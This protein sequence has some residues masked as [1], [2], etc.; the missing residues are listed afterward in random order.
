MYNVISGI[1]NV[2]CTYHKG[3]FLLVLRLPP[4]DDD[5]GH[6]ETKKEHQKRNAPFLHPGNSTDAVRGQNT[7]A[8]NKK[9][10]KGETYGEKN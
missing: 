4:N 9:C 7:Q 2:D 1:T 6:A 3:Y 5:D 8:Q 10:C